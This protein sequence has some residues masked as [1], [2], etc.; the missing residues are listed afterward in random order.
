MITGMMMDEIVKFKEEMKQQ[1]KM[2]DLAL[3]TFYLRLEIHQSFSN[4]KL[5]QA[6]Y[7]VWI[8]E[9]AGMVDCN[10]TQTLMEEWLKLSRDSKAEEGDT[11]LYHKIIGSFCYLINMRPDLIFAMG[12]LIRFMQRPTV[13]HMVALKRVL[14]YI[15][16]TINYSFFY[17]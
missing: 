9:A 14:C 15:V 4:I 7:V 5:C 17:Q 10:S 1:F 12:Y 6:H 11:T 3:L 16:D 13:E 2:A 8:L